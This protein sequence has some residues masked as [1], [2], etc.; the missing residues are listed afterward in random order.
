MNFEY[1]VVDWNGVGG[2][3]TDGMT[4]VLNE[5]GAEGWDL[6]SAIDR[7]RSVRFT[8]KREI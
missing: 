3:D 7:G 8:F 4:K 5:Y 1:V 6:I 2:R